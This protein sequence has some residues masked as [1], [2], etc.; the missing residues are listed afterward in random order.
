[1]SSGFSFNTGGGSGGFG[2][3]GANAGGSGGGFG[4]FNANAGGSNLFGAKS[5]ED[6]KPAAT[7][8]AVSSIFGSA[9]AASKPDASKPTVPFNFG[10]QP[11]AS[12][13][14]AAGTPTPAAPSIF[15][16]GSTASSG[17]MFGAK[18]AAG[19]PLFG[20][21]SAAPATSVAP[22]SFGSL[23]GFSTPTTTAASSLSLGGTTSAATTAKPLF[24]A[25]GGATTTGAFQ[26]GALG[27]STTAAAASSAAATSAADGKAAPFGLKSDTLAAPNPTAGTGFGGFKLSAAPVISGAGSSDGKMTGTTT[28]ALGLSSLGLSS[29]ASST[30]PASSSAAAGA[31]S[32]TESATDLANAA[33]RGKT[34]EEIAQMWTSELT[35]QTR[36]FHTQASTVSYWDRALVQQGKRIT[37]LYDATMAVEAE[38]AALD[39]SLE[40]MEGQ[41]SA[42]Q[43]LLD[44]Y[45]GRVQGIVRKTT[46]RPAGAGKGVT[47]SADE[48]R[49]LVY[50]SAERLNMQLDE[51]TRRLSTLVE[52]VNGVSN[53]NA[54]A[55][56]AEGQRGGAADPLAQ[57]MQILNAHLTSLQWVEAQT[58]QLQDRV[59]T[60]QRVFQDVNA[61]QTSITG[62]YGGGGAAASAA[63]DLYGSDFMAPAAD[64]RRDGSRFTMPGGPAA[65]PLPPVT[66]SF[67]TPM[68]TAR[69]PQTSSMLGRPANNQLS[70]LRTSAPPPTSPFGSTPMRRGF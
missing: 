34:L 40:D 41:Q 68:A 12:A 57:I 13:G 38:Q 47:M 1:M 9:A 42:L 6:T 52:D 65:E 11:A 62:A 10:N 30:V 64:L 67:G 17:G 2:G 49:D 55:G 45:E 48:E 50:S 19:A 4:G 5:S 14:N 15:G 29:S 54:A 66:S 46:A 36:A 23:G 51:L 53:A 32:K 39:Q 44:A 60:A 3:F 20:S 18:P 28:P 69:K 63:D 56:D 26:F 16:A 24:G 7:A 37:E 31:A 21:S 33:L 70:G 59:K 58:S 35:V 27:A 8:T 61:A 22:A 25:T 43:N